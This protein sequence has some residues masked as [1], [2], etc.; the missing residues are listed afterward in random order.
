MKQL[1]KTR[2]M[3]YHQ[4]FPLIWKS[5]L[6]I[7]VLSLL[8]TG[9]LYSQMISKNPTDYPPGT[10]IPPT[11]TIVLPGVQLKA[12]TNFTIPLLVSA[13]F[14][15]VISNIN[16]GCSDIT[17]NSTVTNTDNVVTILVNR[18]CLTSDNN[19]LDFRFTITKDLA[20]ESQNFRVPVIRDSSKIVLTLD[21]SGSMQLTV[22][23]GSGTRIQALKDA[24]NM[25][26]PKLEEF[27]QEG[28]SLG[29]SY[30]SSLV[31]QPSTT[32]FPKNFVSI[33]SNNEPVLANYASY[34]VQNDIAS[35]VPL[36]MTAMAS[37]LLD[38]KNKLLYQKEKT[39][40]TKRMVFL[41]TDGLQNWGPQVNP[42]G[43][44]INNGID[45]LNNYSPF[46]KDS[47]RYYTIAT[48]GAGLAPEILS[49]IATNSGG[50]ALHVVQTSP[51][52]EEWFSVQFCN[53]LAGG[54]PQIVFKRYDNSFSGSATYSFN[55]NENVPKLLIELSGGMADIGM[56]VKKDD[57][58][59]TSYAKLR[60]GSGFRMLSFNLPMV[61]RQPI[62][63]GGKW[64][65][66][67]AGQSSSP[68][69]I[70]ALADFCSAGF[71]FNYF[72]G[73]N[74]NFRRSGPDPAGR[75]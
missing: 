5:V 65:I 68:I 27:Q 48:W 8:N 57:I 56:T 44:S 32:Y 60:Q 13:P 22:D 54:S 63:S 2:G 74:G 39:P 21:I 24:V 61:G 41:F 70:I 43:N 18:K 47:V 50:E 11:G 28:D 9:F 35:R 75:A 62:T 6:L 71:C 16:G 26:V 10:Y 12:S 1:N 49:H 14:N 17:S 69:N 73:K 40:N 72:A 3:I 19:Y 31:Y 20:S 7:L 34:K 64:E 33:T 55:L 36:Q 66:I 45:S 4:D 46:N 58:D 59:V 15:V 37:G 30:Y 23:G 67:L 38:A 25:I 52:L 51:S 53:M 29:I 42:D